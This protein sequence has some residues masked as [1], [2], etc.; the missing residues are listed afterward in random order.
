M[1]VQKKEESPA[2]APP[3][4]P[5]CRKGDKS[6]EASRVRF[7][8][9]LSV[10]RARGID[11][12]KQHLI[13]VFGEERLNEWR[14]FDSTLGMISRRLLTESWRQEDEMERRKKFPAREEGAR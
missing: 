9:H 11:G 1:S 8:H 5:D 10:A 2:K 7:E 13:E 12:L 3:S 6:I 14:A 4:C